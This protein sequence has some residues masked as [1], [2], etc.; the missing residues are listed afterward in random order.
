LIAYRNATY[1][2][3][4]RALPARTPARYHR[5]DEE[6]AT[7]YLCLHP[8]GPLAELMRAHSLRSLDQVRHLRARTWA[9][10]IEPAGLTELRFDNAADFGI[11][12]AVLVDDDWAGCQELGARL[13]ADLAGV[14][15]PSAALPGT[16]NVV[17]FGPR[18]ASPY[19]FEP[20][21]AIDIPASITA[22]GARSLLS[23]L[24]VVRFR[25][26]PHAELEARRRR[27]AF[28]FAEPDWT[29]A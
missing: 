26:Q 21:S 10:R 25:G 17:L 11:A 14:V 16:R 2:T 4:L 28:T 6:S 18:V 9:L 19:L 29:I 27:R 23:L 3:P 7:Q 22:E 1:A 5:G 13:R 8:L 12:P 24:D 20:V 15:V